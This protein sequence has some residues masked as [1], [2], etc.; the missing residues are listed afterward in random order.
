MPRGA[1]VIAWGGPQTCAACRTLMHE[2]TE[3]CPEPYVCLTPGEC[4]H[5]GCR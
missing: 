2:P 3:A 5:A 4:G 1:Q